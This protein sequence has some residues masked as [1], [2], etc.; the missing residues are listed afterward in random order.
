VKSDKF[1]TDNRSS[2]FGNLAVN[3]WIHES[4]A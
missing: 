3:R 4:R 2:D 1:L